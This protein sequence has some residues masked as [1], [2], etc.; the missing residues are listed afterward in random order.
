[1][2]SSAKAP[3]GTAP[4]AR[5]ASIDALRG[6]TILVM[7]FVN[8]VAGVEG[9]PSWM[10]HFY[11]YDADGMTFVDVVFPA[12][13]FIVGM[14]IPFALGKRLER[15]EGRLSIW[16]HVFGRTISLL[17]IGFFMVNS[18]PI[19]KEEGLLNPNLWTLLMYV[20]VLLVWNT[21]PHEPGKKRKT[22][23]GLRWGGVGLL[24]VLA[25]LFRSDEVDHPFFEMRTYW[26][27]IIGLIGWAYF[28]ASASFLF[29]RKN[30]AGLLGVMALLYCV[31][32]ADK[33]GTF[34]GIWLRQY[35]DFGSQLGSH[36]AIVVG[37]VVLGL[38][39]RP[40]SP[41]QGH[42]KR[43]RW[44]LLYA[45]GLWLAGVLLHRLADTH[46]MWIINKNAATPPWCLI[47]SALTIWVWC[48]IY[49]IM[50]MNGVKAWAKVIQPAGEN[51][52]FAYILAPMI[53]A[54]SALIG[55]LVGT[56]PYA[57]LGESFA[58]GF[59]RSIA[60]AFLIT[61]IVGRLKRVGIYLKA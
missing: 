20:G 40:D 42:L 47:S 38:I 6:L 34:D 31:F 26:W 55:D 56:D 45:A 16:R 41:V 5:V 27:G 54:L 21:I 22:M 36:S 39:L 51:P 53:Y 23:I 12:F 35:V 15:G 30:V 10:K 50:D 48:V 2:A 24:V 37:G 33:V 32:V 49:F 61:W 1:M 29:L 52:L 3:T 14:A 8:D 60:F 46:S 9:T 11:P 7:I 17:L 58:V 18:H 4:S 13:L 28:V 25:L 19:A 44:A 59:V 57:L 43:L